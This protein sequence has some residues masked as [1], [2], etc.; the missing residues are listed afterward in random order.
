MVHHPA[1][2]S[3]SLAG[4]SPTPKTMDLDVCR[5]KNKVQIVGCSPLVNN[6]LSGRKFCK[7]DCI[8]QLPVHCRPK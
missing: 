4:I 8:I 6:Y 5:K 1:D 2:L 3:P 7:E